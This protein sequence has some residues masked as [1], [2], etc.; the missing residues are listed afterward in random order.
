M[1]RFIFRLQ[2]VLEVR[3]TA[4]REC[5]A[6][7]AELFAAARELD[8]RRRSVERELA[9][10]VQLRQAGQNGPL[11]VQHLASVQRYEQLLRGDLAIVGEQIQALEQ[12]IERERQ[13]LIAADRQMRLLERLREKQLARHRQQESASESRELDDLLRSAPGEGPRE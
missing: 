4:R 13:S 2:S 6:R 8:G 12:R 9:A 7:L 11:D 5:R 10:A 1:R 3:A